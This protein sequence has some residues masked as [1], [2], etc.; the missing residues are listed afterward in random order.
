MLSVLRQLTATPSVAL[1]KGQGPLASVK[2]GIPH[3]LPSDGKQLAAEAQHFWSQ[4]N[5]V[6]IPE[7]VRGGVHGC[8]ATGC[9]AAAARCAWMWLLMWCTRLRR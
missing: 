1:C 8:A 7:E 3:G 6:Y 4:A 2:L 5:V 9:A